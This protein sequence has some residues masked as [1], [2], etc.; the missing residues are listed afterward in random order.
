MNAEPISA[1][2]ASVV[3]APPGEEAAPDRSLA[4][5]AFAL[6]WISYASYYLTRKNFSVAKRSIELDLGVSRT[7]LGFIDTGFLAAYALGQ[8][9]WGLLADKVGA[10]RVLAV[11]MLATAACS[12]LFGV[13]ST[14]ALFAIVF[15]LNGIGQSS[16]WS[17]NLKVMTEWFPKRTRGAVMGL[18]STCYQFGS[19]VA[20]PIAGFL[21]TASVLGWRL[22]F[23]APAVWVALIGVVLAI[24]LPEAAP[25]KDAVGK[26]AFAAQV[27]AERGR[28]L[29]TPLVWALGASYFFMKLIRYI[30]LFWLPYYME[31]TLHYSKG[32]A[33]TIP[34]AFEAGGLLGAV[35]IGAA[36][37][38][39]FGGR[40][41]GVALCSLVML[42]GA[43]P[44]FGWASGH[45]VAWNALS[46]AIVGFFLFG[47]D[48]LLSATAA[49]DVGGPAASATAG[50]L[51]NGVGSLGPIIGSSLAA[52]ISLKYGWSTLF[53]LLGVCSIVSAVVLVPFQLREGRKSAGAAGA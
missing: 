12:M 43:M 8:F 11:G 1:P 48:T 5:R 15:A 34:L 51:I 13:S 50:G 41:L 44:L 52:A 38:R 2:S 25:P 39:F 47:P 26:E 33:A 16:G 18:W 46:L 7:S 4:R 17:A 40:R 29:R 10:R 22:A 30:L 42:T 53:G 37:D 45:G 24:W 19:L 49:Q 28:V 35:T 21:L 14:F 27:K 6:T 9:G 23:F 32:L 31:E 36:S 20:S 3:T